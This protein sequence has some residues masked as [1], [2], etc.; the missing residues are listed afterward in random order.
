MWSLLVHQ[1]QHYIAYLLTPSLN[2][3]DLSLAIT[4]H[5]SP[6]I[7]DKAALLAFPNNSRFRST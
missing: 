3:S 7:A 4:R 1:A 2:L 6:N 5:K